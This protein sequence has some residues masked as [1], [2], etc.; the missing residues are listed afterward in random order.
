MADHK[1]EITV[2]FNAKNAQ[3]GLDKLEDSVKDVG[4]AT[5]RTGRKADK[6]G[7]EL[8]QMAGPGVVAGINR[9]RGALVGAAAAIGGLMVA[10][11]AAFAFRGLITSS[12][13]L[14]DQLHKT[15]IRTGASTEF[16]S[17]MTF[18]AEQSGAGFEALNAG[19]RR[20]ARVVSDA[21]NGLVEAERGFEGVGL[22]LGNLINGDGSLKTI[23]QLLPMVA[24]G[25]SRMTDDT[26]AAAVAQELFGRGGTQLLVFLKEGSAGLNKF[27][28]E[29]RALGVSFGSDFAQNSANATDAVNRLN[30]AWLGLKVSLAG[31]VLKAVTDVADA[32]T[33]QFATEE[34]QTKF[35][36]FGQSIADA[37]KDV[38]EMM[39]RLPGIVSDL[40]TALRAA[41]A[42]AS[43]VIKAA[44]AVGNVA[45]G[46]GRAVPTSGTGYDTYSPQYFIDQAN[47]RPRGT[48][49]TMEAFM[50]GGGTADGPLREQTQAV[51]ENTE[52]LR[53]ALDTPGLSPI[54][55]PRIGGLRDA[56]VEQSR[57]RAFTVELD[58]GVKKAAKSVNALGEEIGGH[59]ANT[60]DSSLRLL[61][62]GS[63]DF[64]AAMKNIAL[65][66]VADLASTGVRGVLSKL[67]IIGPLF[68]AEGGMIRGGQP[69]V[70]SVPVLA[71]Q[72]EIIV[73]TRLS[74]DLVSF[75]SSLAPQPSGQYAGGGQVAAGAGAF[76]GGAEVNVYISGAPDAAGVR[77]YV[78]SPEFYEQI[79]DAI[80]GGL[81]RV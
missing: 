57:R 36:E 20:F 26:K 4:R 16:L 64:A 73:P 52:V 22:S 51:R 14:G 27:Q 62:R 10:R 74:G 75:F 76:G 49:A 38:P 44:K 43:F 3:R 71:Q 8:K 47:S 25:F 60:I 17:E 33:K 9:M 31:P 35:K 46:G 19:M 23:E 37:V 56:P 65:D 45:T 80:S 72:G 61:I 13:A 79:N 29:A 78:Q 1:L 5:D 48:P 21:Q 59:F 69:G 67:P 58:D 28:L 77:D 55:D 34:F 66:L 6:A 81:V 70:D 7:R 39:S 40:E 18:A 12:M 41:A 42:T 68:G 63:E 32:L 30:K 54:H 24:D 11:Q 15:S 50:Y 53:E 2:E